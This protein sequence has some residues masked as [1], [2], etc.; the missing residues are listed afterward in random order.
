VKAI[1]IGWAKG[2]VGCQEGREALAD[3]IIPLFMQPDAIAHRT[4]CRL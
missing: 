2:V 4:L 3:C 1:W